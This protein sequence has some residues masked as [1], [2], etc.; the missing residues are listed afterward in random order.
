M[1][2]FTKRNALLGWIV[3]RVARRKLEHR[4]ED[5]IGKG[6]GRRRGLVAGLGLAAG[7]VAAI[8]L[9]TRRGRAEPAHAGA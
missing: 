2:I 6:H 3:Y 8:A 9:F 7:A 5:A 4:V 1:R